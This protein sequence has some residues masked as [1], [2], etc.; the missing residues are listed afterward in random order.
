MIKAIIAIS[1]NSNDQEV[2]GPNALSRNLVSGTTISQLVSNMTK[3]TEDGSNASLTTGVSIVIELIRKNNSDYDLTP[4]MVLAFNNQP[5]TSR[6]PIY[7]GTMLRVFANSISE[8]QALLLSPK[9]IRMI[10]TSG[11]GEI[12]SLGF[13]RFRICELYAELLHCSNMALL[14]DPRG[15]MVVRERDAE[16]ERL[17]ALAKAEGASEAKSLHH[18]QTSSEDAET[19]KDNA[20]VFDGR[21]TSSS[22]NSAFEGHD[23]VDDA[24]SI[25]KEHFQGANDSPSTVEQRRRS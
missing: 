20:S 23:E 25:E 6:D 14:N 9:N 19:E 10:K 15:E 17:K 11:Y 8:F 16:R 3:A 4:V 13:E 1:A 7:L 24:F 2:I 5:P 12:E 21:S 18:P 22:R